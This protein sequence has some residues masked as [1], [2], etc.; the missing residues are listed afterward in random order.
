MLARL[1][2]DTIGY[3]SQFLRVIPRV[4]ALDVVA[5]PLAEDGAATTPR[6]DEAAREEAAQLA[7]RA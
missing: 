3:V 7:L 5:E 2:R 6:A 4:P 1:R